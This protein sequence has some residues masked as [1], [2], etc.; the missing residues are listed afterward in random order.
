M[1]YSSKLLENAVE[2]FSMLPG[3]GKKTALRLALFL[4]KQDVKTIDAFGSSFIKMRNEIKYCHNCHNISDLTTCELCSDGSRDKELICVVESI[5]DVMAIESTRQHKGLYHVLGG[6]ISPIDGIGPGDLNIESLVDKI[7]ENSVREIILAL[8]TTIE[9]ETTN[10]YLF[11]RLKDFNV[12]ISVIARGIAFG[13]ELEYA[14]EITLGR[15]ILNRI[16]YEKSVN[17]NKM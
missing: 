5:K 2:Q 4:L 1:N 14:D 3:I 15:S 10:F 7:R 12:N 8:N 11:R 17:S 16:P 13:D 6:I 9:G